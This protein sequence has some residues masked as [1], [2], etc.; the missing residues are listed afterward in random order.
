MDIEYEA[1]FPDV[2]KEEVRKILKKAGARLIKPEFMQRRVVFNLPIGHEIKNSW[3]RVRDE[4][5]KITMSLKVVDGDR[6]ESQ[7][8]IYLQVS[9]FKQA[10]S[11]L[12]S[13]GCKKKSFQ[14]SKGNYGDLMV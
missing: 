14:E 2:D 10:E 5:D 13:V 4:G 1:T 6:I 12:I 7:K 9:D 11:L 3:L 8:E